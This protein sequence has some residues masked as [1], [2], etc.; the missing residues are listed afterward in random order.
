MSTSVN[1][2]FPLRMH[3][4]RDCQSVKVID[5]CSV[6][7]YCKSLMWTTSITRLMSSSPSVATRSAKK[8]A[9]IAMAYFAS[10]TM[11]FVQGVVSISGNF[12]LGVNSLVNVLADIIHR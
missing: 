7:L 8:T 6:A 1:N 10:A 3:H 4:H 11:L 5:R 12:V 9:H 2:V